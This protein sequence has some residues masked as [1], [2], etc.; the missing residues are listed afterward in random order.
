MEKE[1]YKLPPDMGF[2]PPL[3]KYHVIIRVNLR[4]R[5]SIWGRK[6]SPL[7]PLNRFLS[8]RGPLAFITDLRY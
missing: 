5:S 4:M 8:P 2:R 3:Q 6:S 1:R 7:H